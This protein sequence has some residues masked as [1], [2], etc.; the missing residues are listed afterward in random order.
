MCRWEDGLLSQHKYTRSRIDGG[1]DSI[2]AEASSVE[3]SA[4]PPMPCAIKAQAKCKLG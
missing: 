1:R 3:K 4:F 2:G